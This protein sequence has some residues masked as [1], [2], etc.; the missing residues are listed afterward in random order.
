MTSI[1]VGGA[2][3]SALASPLYEYGGWTLVAG[4]ASAFPLV[5]L[6]HYLVIGRPH[7]ARIG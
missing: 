5:A 2:L 3:S 6:I 4:V 1:F 7:A